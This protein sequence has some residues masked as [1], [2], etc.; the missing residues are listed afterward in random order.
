MK[1]DKKWVL[2]SSLSRALTVARQCVSRSDRSGLP[3][4]AVGMNRAQELA[5]QLQEP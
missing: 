5:R 1:Q 2:R 4:F 3:F